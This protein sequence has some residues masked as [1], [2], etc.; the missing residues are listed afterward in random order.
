MFCYSKTVVEKTPKNQSNLE[1]NK[2]GGNTISDLKVKLQS[3]NNQDSMI[4]AKNR[5]PDQ[6]KK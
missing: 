4:L 6:Q 3:Y 5:H 2:A 1:K